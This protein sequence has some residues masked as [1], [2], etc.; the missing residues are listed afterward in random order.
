MKFTPL[1]ATAAIVAGCVQTPPSPNSPV[2]V[3]NPI[4]LAGEAE[5]GAEVASELASKGFAVETTL[6]GRNEG[7]RAFCTSEADAMVITN[8][9]P[10][11]HQRCRDL[12]AGAGWGWSAMSAQS[13]GTL[14]IRRSF[15]DAFLAEGW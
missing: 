15:A 3:P 11:E 4:V 7:I 13:D 5:A 1:V 10:E 14:Y 9:T 6:N 8:I 2:P 12:K